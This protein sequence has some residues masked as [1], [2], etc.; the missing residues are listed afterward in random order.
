[1]SIYVTF[2]RTTVTLLNLQAREAV[3]LETQRAQL[4]GA[5]EAAADR[6]RVVEAQNKLLHERLEKIEAGQAS[7]DVLAPGE[8]PSTPPT[9]NKLLPSRVRAEKAIARSSSR[10]DSGRSLP[11][12]I[13]SGLPADD[14]HEL[15][16]LV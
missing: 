2:D 15:S 5:A 7:G 12:L 13:T 4:Q 6:Q 8:T 10:L 9:C 14:S 11:V 1:M 3:E 16:A